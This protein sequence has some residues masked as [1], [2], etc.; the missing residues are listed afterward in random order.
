MKATV[1]SGARF[2][3][4]AEPFAEGAVHTTPLGYDRQN[5]VAG[6]P[7]PLPASAEL[8][9]R[10]SKCDEVLVSFQGKLGDSL[11]ALSAVRALHDWFSLRP[12]ASPTFR[13]EGQHAA[14]HA[15]SGLFTGSSA[16]SSR[17]R[18]AVVGDHESV[19]HHQSDAYVSIVC[20]PAALPCWST[21]GLAHADMPARYYLALE[22]RLGLRLPSERPFAPV[23]TT[24]PNRL[25]RQ[26]H[27]AGWFGGLTIAAVTATSWPERK[28]YTA[29]RF[30]EVVGRIADARRTAVGLLLIGGSEDGRVR[31]AAVQ[32]ARA[33][34]ALHLDGVA[35]DE[36]ADVFPYCD[37]VLGN[38]TGLTHL[39]A[40]A[41]ASDGGGPRVLGLYARHAH[42]KWRTGLPHHH[43]VA[44]PFSE[45][46]HQGDLCPVRDALA[47][48]TDIGLDAI[49]P[50]ALARVC[51]DLLDGADR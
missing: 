31:I 23:L 5:L 46:M 1:T 13:A 32:A 42:S 16:A 21:D 39:A 38:D 15:R 36:L 41:R 47:P 44:T 51:A 10:L 14:L 34:R 30:T 4:G 3:P 12:T 8:V 40:L 37:L 7:L 49:T 11:L 33:V 43:A 48:T 24:A 22:R 26:L 9:D 35:A 19:A 27:E 29:E 45:R 17:R 2:C 6:T 50:A 28:D 20:D 18:F 25:T